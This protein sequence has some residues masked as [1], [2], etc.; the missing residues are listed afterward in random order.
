LWDESDIE[1]I[2]AYLPLAGGISARKTI[3]GFVSYRCKQ[4]LRTLSILQYHLTCADSM[5]A[6]QQTNACVLS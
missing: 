1:A 3:L 5:P 4:T 6:E 2:I